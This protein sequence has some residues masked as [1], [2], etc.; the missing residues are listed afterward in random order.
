MT[1]RAALLLALKGRAQA[2]QQGALSESGEP[3]ETNVGEQVFTGEVRSTGPDDPSAA[4]LIKF[5]D[6]VPTYQGQGFFIRLPIEIHAIVRTDLD[7]PAA[8]L[9]ALIGD[10]KRAVELED[11]TLG[12]LVKR[13]LE[14]GPVVPMEREP[15]SPF[16]GAVLTYIAPYQEGWGR[17]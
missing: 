4:L 16:V 12:G 7:D 8:L 3:F 10:V 17:P 1:R 2:I 15:G 11:R 5:G 13:M 14:R 6:E 9:E